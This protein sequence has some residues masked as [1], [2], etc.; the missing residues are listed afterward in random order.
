MYSIIFDKKTKK[1]E[2]FRTKKDAEKAAGKERIA[3]VYTGYIDLHFF[4]PDIEK[5]VQAAILR[6][7]AS[8]KIK[9]EN[10][11]NFFWK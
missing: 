8:G 2:Y 9:R 11:K 4:A 3:N 6:D 7:I 5:D 10:Y 1:I